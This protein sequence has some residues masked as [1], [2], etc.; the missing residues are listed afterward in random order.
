MPRIVH[1]LKLHKEAPGLDSPPIP[2]PLGQRIYDHISQEA[3]KA[4]LQQ[5]TIL[6]NENR[7]KLTDAEAR[8]FLKKSMEHFFFDKDNE[9]EF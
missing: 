3:W 2:G 9:P 5:Q 1:C 8:T 7:L 6:I 4:W